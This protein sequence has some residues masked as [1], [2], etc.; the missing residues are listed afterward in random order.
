MNF[1]GI[2]Y[3]LG[4]FCFPVSFLAFL[5]ILYSSYFDYFL[6]LDSYTV[7]LFVSM[8]FGAGFFLIGKN[9]LK[10]IYFHEQLFLIILIYLVSSLLICIPYYLSN[11][12]ISF[13]NSFFEAVS[14]V[15]GTGFSIFDNIK[16]LDPTLII[17]RS[18][19]QWIGGLFF[20]IFLLLFFSNTQFNYKLNKLVF[21]S[22]KSL[23]PEMNIKKLSLKI[24][25]LYALIT[26]IIFILFTFSGVRLFN[27]LNLS[28][29]V[30]SAGGFLST[31]NLNQIIK[32]NI[33]ELMLIIALFISM[34]NIFFFYNIFNEKNFFKKHYE[35]VSLFVLTLLISIVLLF[36]LNDQGFLRILINV[37]SSVSTSGITLGNFPNNYSLFFIFLTIVGGSILSNTS[38]IKFLR[39]F[40]LIKASSIEILKLV[41]PNNIIN[42]NILFSENKINNENIKIAFLIF[43]SFFISL[44]ILS[45]ILLFDKI[46]FENSFRLSILTLTN[47]TTSSIFGITNINFGNLL[48][49]SK[50][51]IIIFMIIGK[52][53]LISL[54]LL[55]KQIFFKN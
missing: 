53:E 16:Y 29:T 23:N 51:F 34:F 20:L 36:F 22:D 42:Q 11:Y 47:T 45:G 41:K 30:V 35:D 33:Q 2:S 8:I 39:M 32:T 12:Q 50:I 26:I 48:T 21:G 54:F 14:G 13:L 44:F 46:N 55:V 6:N 5:N 40:I 25:F 9:A 24:F 10:K 31:N 37:L 19:S 38:G 15:T 52:I 7:T 49:N 28:M 3:Y 17:W 4:L 18:S 1:K 27:G 43:I